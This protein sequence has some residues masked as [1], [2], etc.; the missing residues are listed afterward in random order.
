MTGQAVCAKTARV[1]MMVDHV[2]HSAILDSSCMPMQLGQ[3]ATHDH[4]CICSQSGYALVITTS[5]LLCTARSH[6]PRNVLH[7]PS[8]GKDYC[9]KA[10][11]CYV[12]PL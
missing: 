2:E 1:N 3:M 5:T 6:L 12:G 9:D 4:L 8:T 7:S 11:L 10:R